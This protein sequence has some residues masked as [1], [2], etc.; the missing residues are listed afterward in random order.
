MVAPSIDEAK[1]AMQEAMSRT[2][3]AGFSGRDTGA[4]LHFDA[5]IVVRPQQEVTCYW[6]DAAL[7]DAALGKSN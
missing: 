5:T 4:E 1:A 6:Q 2:A 3:E 7:L